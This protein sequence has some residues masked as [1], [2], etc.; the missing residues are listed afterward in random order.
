MEISGLATSQKDCDDLLQMCIQSACRNRF[1]EPGPISPA[2]AKCLS[3]SGTV[4]MLLGSRM[5]TNVG[6]YQSIQ[7]TVCECPARAETDNESSFSPATMQS[8]PAFA[9]ALIVV[10]TIV[11]V[12]LL[13]VIFVLFKKMRTAAQTQI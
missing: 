3:E 9:M 6:V 12:A 7:E 5:P 2:F 11:L 8:M 13:I 1:P 4:R 10:S